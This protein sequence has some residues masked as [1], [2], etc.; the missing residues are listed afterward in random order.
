MMGGAMRA[1][2]TGTIFALEL[3]HDINTFPALLI[4][5]IVAYGFTVLVMKRS[6]LTEKVA[7][8]G[9]HINYEYSVDPLEMVSVR[10]VMTA[11]VVTIPAKTPV[12][13][14]LRDYFSRRPTARATRPTRWWTATA[15]C[16]ASSRGAT[17]WRT[18]CRRA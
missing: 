14:V 12:K 13:Q 3:T 17:C 2:L 5:S 6:I 18:G 15:S 8:R 10:E 11:E 16:S 7:R 1:P 9:Y 4:A